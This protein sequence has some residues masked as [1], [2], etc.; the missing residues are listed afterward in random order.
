M[1]VSSFTPASK[2]FDDNFNLKRK[3]IVHYENFI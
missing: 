2:T 3:K 1:W